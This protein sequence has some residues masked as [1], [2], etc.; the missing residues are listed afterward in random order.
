M[1]IANLA[2]AAGISNTGFN[3]NRSIYRPMQRDQSHMSG[4]F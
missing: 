2:S 4:E 3:E 1:Q